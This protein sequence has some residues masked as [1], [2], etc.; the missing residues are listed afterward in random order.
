MTRDD[1]GSVLMLVPAA[2]LVL[3]ILG[4][5]CVDS[6]VVFFAERDLANR[7][8][9]VASDAANATV[10]DAAFYGSDDGALVLDD[11]KA[12]AYARLAFAPDRVPAGYESWSG[13]AETDGRTVTVV[14]TARVRYVFT[15]AIPGAPDTATVEARTVATAH[16]G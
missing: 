13:E 16:G 1:R 9:A 6:A 14:A 12:R 8:A 7:T 10:S 3:L 4:A 5:I 11:A 15:K 2:V